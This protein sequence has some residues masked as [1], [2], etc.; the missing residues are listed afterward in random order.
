MSSTEIN[1]KAEVYYT[2]LPTRGFERSYK[3]WD[4]L[5]VQICYGIAAWFFL[6]GAQTGLY[7]P[8]K[9]AIPTILAGQCIP[10]FLIVGCGIVAS[11]Y[12]VEQLTSTTGIFGHRGTTLVLIFYMFCLYP[13]QAMLCLLFGQSATKFTGSLFGESIFSSSFGVTFFGVCALVI[14]GFIAWLGPNALKWF[15][16][17]SAICMFT[18]L[19]GLIAYVFYKYGIDYI[20]N[21]QPREPYM[22]DGQPSVAWSRASALE[23][24]VG[25]GLSWAF[26]FGQWTRLADSESTAFHGCMWGWGFLA[27]IAG[28]FAAFTAL[29]TGIYD[30]TIWLVNISEETGIPFLSILGLILMAVANV[31]SFATATYPATISLR[32]KFP[33]LPWIGALAIAIVPILVLLNEDVYNAINKVYA[34]IACLSSIYGAI[35]VADLFFVCKGRFSMRGMFNQS[36]GYSYWKGFNPGALIAIAAGLA[37]YLLILNPLTWESPTGLFPYIS[38]GIPTFLFIGIVYVVCMKCWILKKF[39][40]TFL[41]DI[42]Y[43][44]QKQKNHT[45]FE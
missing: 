25:M 32:S 45:H 21:A 22:V 30:P 26:F 42:K 44:E 10:L 7:L 14:G 20:W 3:F 13:S 6:A 18:I 28:V 43:P 33:K 24:N 11:R 39:P 16:R 1:S 9:E 5:A 12:G 31:S 41:N 36:K 17:I 40:V 2:L 15:T 34:F 4:L 8:A 38:A 23:T 29:A 35:V 27:C 19:A 37:C